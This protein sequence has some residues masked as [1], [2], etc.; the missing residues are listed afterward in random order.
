MFGVTDRGAVSVVRFAWFLPMLGYGPKVLPSDAV[1]S[2]FTVDGFPRARSTYWSLKIPTNKVE[3]LRSN[4][5][6]RQYE[7][8]QLGL[9][10]FD[11]RR[12]PK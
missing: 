1:W 7:R 2:C 3:Q 11:T 6:Y 4:Q 9:D 10:M 8:A 5:L 12:V